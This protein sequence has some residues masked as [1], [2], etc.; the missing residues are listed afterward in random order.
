MEQIFIISGE[1]KTDISLEFC[2]FKVKMG[3]CFYFL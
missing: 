3:F 1:V 2:T